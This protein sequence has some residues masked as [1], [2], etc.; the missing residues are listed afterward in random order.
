MG[1]VMAG[2]KPARSQVVCPAFLGTEEPLYVSR[3]RRGPPDRR[4][5][6][7]GWLM[8]SVL[9]ALS[10]SSLVGGVL[11]AAVGTHAA[12]IVR[13]GE[14]PRPAGGSM[15]AQAGAKGDRFRPEPAKQSER[16][17]LQ[18]SMM[19]RHGDR[20]VI[21]V[22]PFTL[23]RASLAQPVAPEV[24]AAVPAYN[25]LLA[26]TASASPEARPGAAEAVIYGAEVDG[27]VAVQVSD[28]P[29]RGLA[30]APEAQLSDREAA[31][32]VEEAAPFLA[33][34]AVEVASHA[35]ID[36]GRFAVA[37]ADAASLVSLG[38]AI[39]PENVS[40][41]GK[42]DEVPAE[43]EFDEKIITLA[44]GDT[45]L[46]LLQKEGANP[47][48]A[49]DAQAAMV[50]NFSF[51][52]RAGQM[53]RLAL[54][55][56]VEAR[57]R[58]IRISLYEEGNHLATVALA[59]THRFVAAEEPLG[60]SDFGPEEPAV[61]IGRLPTVHDGIWRVGLT[62]DVPEALL[63][64]FV[65]V[66]SYDFDLQARLAPADAVELVYHA[67]EEAG[68]EGEIVYAAIT[69]GDQARRYY[70]FR[71][72]DDG[73]VDY[74]DETGKSSK[75]FLMRKPMAIGRFRSG[76][77]SR[78]HPILGRT[79]MHTGVDWSAPR[80]TPVV[81]SGDGTVT[82]RKWKGGYGNH[83]EIRHR[84]GYVTTYSHLSAFARGVS[85]GDRVKQGQVI[86]YIG[87]TGLS[88]GPHLHYEV[89]VNGR[90]VD[91]MKIKLPRGRVLEGEALA[92]FE[93]DRARLDA[94]L[95][96][97]GDQNRFAA[98]Q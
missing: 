44:E 82:Y 76:F 37:S 26:I 97:D 80:G 10:A 88:T 81:A 34:G 2:S 13:P 83:V 6:G 53:L 75:K 23:V 51:D 89:M 61:E 77:G 70:R 49:A 9:I 95:A 45:L 17:T 15:L 66:V 32:A 29:L 71:A 79:R 22:R 58:P 86:G 67:G 43:I 64:G 38:V 68:D 94:L 84:N 14:G 19:M 8:G 91:P 74:Y 87:S 33:D 21:R 39:V 59:D 65:E 93:K 31:L 41:V 35:V 57:S 4:R 24:A 48:E 46:R 54:A 25:P 60:E 92:A 7:L 28:F 73:T 30:F 90:Y 5:V 62:N 16:R 12:A 47:F 52:F 56:D 20:D 69:I 85:A 78:R 98:A 55:E 1:R 3:M 18:V 36:P 27:E 96:R 50:A 40:L 63:R 42:S 11:H 72:P